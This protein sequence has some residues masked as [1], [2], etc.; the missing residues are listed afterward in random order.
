MIKQEIHITL[1]FDLAIGKVNLNEIVYI[2]GSDLL[3]AHLK[4]IIEKTAQDQIPVHRVY[5]GL[6]RLRRIE[7]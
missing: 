2:K 1:Q 6:F 7:I 4:N 3:L 5:G